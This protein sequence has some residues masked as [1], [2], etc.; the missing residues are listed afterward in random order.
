MKGV[1]IK[2][3]EVF[4]LFGGLTLLLS[5]PFIADHSFTLWAFSKTLY[6]IGVALF[7]FDK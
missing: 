1:T 5:L 7:L 2:L 6:G 4:L 3:S